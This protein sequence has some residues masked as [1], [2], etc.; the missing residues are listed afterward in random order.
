[1]PCV[2]GCSVSEKRK[3]KIPPHLGYGESGAPPTIPGKLLVPCLLHVLHWLGC[4]RRK[5]VFLLSQHNA[6]QRKW[7]SS[8]VLSS[9]TSNT[10]A[11]AVMITCNFDKQG[12]TWCPAG[13]AT[14][15]FETELVK[16]DDH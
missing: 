14:L 2:A 9:C 5:S 10:W 12:V 8:E 6:L 16:I 15:I 1:M 11:A 7:C 3:L 13:G 4:G